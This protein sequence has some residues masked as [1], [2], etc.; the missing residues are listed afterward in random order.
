MAEAGHDRLL[1]LSRRADQ[2]RGAECLSLSYHLPLAADATA[3]QP[4]GQ[5]DVDANGKTGRGL[6][7]ET[8]HPSSL[9]E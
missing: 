5:D 4:E 9:A 2:Q 8:S 6:A 3:A 7:T 1:Q